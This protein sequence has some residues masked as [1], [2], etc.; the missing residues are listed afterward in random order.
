MMKGTLKIVKGRVEEATG[1]LIDSNKLR[2][3]G[4]MDQSVGH[5]QKAV[6]ASMRKTKKMI[7]E[8]KNKVDRIAKKA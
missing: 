4:L 1:V 3:E 6:E 5:A 2:A 8:I 7:Q